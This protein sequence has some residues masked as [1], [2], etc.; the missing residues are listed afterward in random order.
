MAPVVAK[1]AAL[2]ER[3]KG[4]AELDRKRGLYAQREARWDCIHDVEALIEEVSP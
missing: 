2:V 1:L 3:W 4:E